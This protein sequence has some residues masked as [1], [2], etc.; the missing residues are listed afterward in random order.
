MRDGVFVEPVTC[1]I[2]EGG[3]PGDLDGDGTVAFA[4]F[5][6]LSTNFGQTDQPYENGD[7]DCDGTIAFADFLTMSS[8]FG[9]TAAAAS[10][11]EPSSVLMLLCGLAGLTVRRRR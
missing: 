8:N 3:I 11:P 7:I 6:A 10:V 9:Q 5:L 1:S 2:P 4:D